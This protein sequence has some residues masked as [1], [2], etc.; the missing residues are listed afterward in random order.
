MAKSK[1]ILW[2]GI[3][4]AM[5]ELNAPII[6]Q[7]LNKFPDCLDQRA[8]QIIEMRYGIHGGKSETLQKIADSLGVSRERIRQIEKKAIRK[9]THPSRFMKL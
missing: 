4:K 1:G 3:F 6:K 9:L 7:I 2:R 5:I 8:R